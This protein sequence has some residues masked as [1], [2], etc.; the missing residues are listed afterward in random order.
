MLDAT[1]SAVSTPLSASSRITRRNGKVRETETPPP[2][3]DIPALISEKDMVKNVSAILD[4]YR[5][6][7][8]A[9]SRPKLYLRLVSYMVVLTELAT[10]LVPV[11]SI[12]FQWMTA[13]C[14]DTPTVTAIF[15]LTYWSLKCMVGGEADMCDNMQHS[16]I[17]AS[18]N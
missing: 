17:V 12:G 3:P 15:S 1:S 6:V 2:S 5:G 16:C 13:L 18:S 8:L 7:S 14:R 9:K 4:Q 10:L 11:I